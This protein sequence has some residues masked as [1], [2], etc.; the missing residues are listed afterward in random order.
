MKGA[1]P[2]K[3]YLFVVF[4]AAVAVVAAL[5]HLHV[6]WVYWGF[7]LALA[8]VQLPVWLRLKRRSGALLLDLGRPNKIKF[9]LIAALG[10]FVA[11]S[12]ARPTTSADLLIELLCV[13]LLI[14]TPFMFLRG[15]SV[16]ERG[17]LTQERLIEWSE[18]ISYTC[19]EATGKLA[20]R[21]R[22]AG[23]LRSIFAIKPLYDGVKTWPVSPAQQA[24]LGE[25]LAQRVLTQT[26]AAPVAG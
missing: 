5:D 19:E 3:A 14:W 18:V 17:I 11:V 8:L 6:L 7:F 20:V 22:G 9:V 23:L 25:I 15:V 2:N 10:A 12:Y 24:A 26:A 21:V 4:C 1:S 13:V 16:R